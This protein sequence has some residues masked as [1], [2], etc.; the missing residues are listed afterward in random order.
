MIK[1]RVEDSDIVYYTV[2]ATFS[3]LN[4][5]IKMVQLLTNEKF[6]PVVTSKIITIEELRDLYEDSLNSKL[7]NID[8]SFERDYFKCDDV[9]NT[10]LSDRELN[11]IHNRVSTNSPIVTSIYDLFKEIVDLQGML[12][13][14]DEDNNLLSINAFIP[15]Y[16]QSTM[17]C[18]I[19]LQN[20]EK[21]WFSYKLI[22]VENGKLVSSPFKFII[23]ADY[24]SRID[25]FEL[26]NPKPIIYSGETYLLYEYNKELPIYAFSEDDL[27]IL[28]SIVNRYVYFSEL[29]KQLIRL[30]DI[31][32][33]KLTDGIYGE[34]AKEDTVIERK[35]YVSRYNNSYI[36]FTLDYKKP[37]S[38]R[39]LRI[40]ALVLNKLIPLLVNKKITVKGIIEF[41]NSNGFNTIEKVLTITCMEL[42]I[43][44]GD[45]PMDRL[46]YC[47][48]AKNDYKINKFKADTYLYMIRACL[49]TMEVKLPDNFI[50]LKGGNVPF[51]TI[52][53]RRSENELNL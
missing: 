16:S 38:D 23:P 28:P 39:L 42:I 14:T 46:S 19:P 48:K 4:G 30:S 45:I 9:P 22:Y 11:T 44:G 2:N 25:R 32:I 7:I 3:D 6:S 47:I 36:K 13:T 40:L 8:F 20:A 17:T 43:N 26:K 27:Q 18:S 21:Q 52:V 12:I 51:T 31:M 5:N 34:K 29:Y 35:D 24:K 41:L 49:F 1:L 50:R 53:E 37:T 15:N 33:G 10:K